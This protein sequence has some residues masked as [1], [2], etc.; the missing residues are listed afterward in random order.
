MCEKHIGRKSTNNLCLKCSWGTCDTKTVKRDHI[1]SHIRVHVPLKPHGCNMCGKSF[2]RPQDLKKHVKVCVPLLPRLTTRP[3]RMIQYCFPR[4]PSRRLG[5]ISLNTLALGP[6]HP[7][8]ISP[9]RPLPTV[10]LLCP[11][12]VRTPVKGCIPRTVTSRKLPMTLPSP[13]T[14]NGVSVL[15]AL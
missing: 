3:M 7:R 10:S 14:V 15:A 4:Q 6:L 13:G 11:P 5:I 9:L 8:R 2:K 1:T 12:S